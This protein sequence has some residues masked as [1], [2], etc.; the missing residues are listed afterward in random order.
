MEIR[1]GIGIKAFKIELDSINKNISISKSHKY[2]E[3]M[4]NL[5][6]HKLD[7]RYLRL[8]TSLKA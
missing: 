6:Q 4:G 1:N 5:K 8:D 2:K 3:K 7:K